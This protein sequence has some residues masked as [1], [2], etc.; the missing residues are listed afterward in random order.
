MAR[1]NL[2]G[3][4]FGRLLVVKFSHRD[5]HRNSYWLCKC[6]CGNERIVLGNS[7]KNSHTKSCGCLQRERSSKIHRSDLVGQKF[8]RLLVLEDVGTNKWG[9]SRWLCRCNCGNEIIVLVSGLKSNHT[10]SCGCYN[11]ER[12]SETHYKHGQSKTK[13]Y[14]N[15]KR[16]RRYAKKK[17]QTPPDA[18]SKKIQ[19]IYS[20]CEL[21]SQ[22][23]EDYEVDHIKPISKGGQHHQDNL[24]ILKAELNWEKNNKW[25]LTEKEKI[26]YQGITLKDLEKNSF[27]IFLDAA[28]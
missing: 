23:G 6:E 17:N 14:N 9:V 25:P 21:L 24:Q 26:R 16:M 27:E 11:R 5:K 15:Q 7:L 18:N 28:F 1:L 10:Q 12:S 19:F 3:E 2:V 20:F 22:L 4:K 13:A 8:G